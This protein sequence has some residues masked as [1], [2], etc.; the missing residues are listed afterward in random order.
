MTIWRLSDLADAPAFGV[1]G[2]GVE[3]RAVLDWAA[4]NAPRATVHVLDENPDVPAAVAEAAEYRCHLGTERIRELVVDPPFQVLVRS[5]GVPVR[6]E[7]LE[8]A[9]DNGVHVTTLTD[10]WLADDPDVIT[11]GVTGTKGK[12]TTV[13]LLAHVLNQAGWSAALVGNIGRPVLAVDDNHE[14]AVIELS[15]YMLADLH[16]ELDIGVVLNLYREHTDWHGGHEV[17]RADKLRL[18]DLAERVVANRDDPAVRAATTT[19]DP[20]W[21][22][23]DGDDLVCG[24]QRLPAVEVKQA[25]RAAGL[26]GEHNL[27]NAAAALTAAGLVGLDPAGSIGFLSSTP[28]LAHRMEMVASTG[29]GRRWIDDSIATVPE[30]TIAAL[31]TLEGAPLVLIAGGTDRGQ[32]FA[33]LVEVIAT[34]SVIGLAT[35]GPTGPRLAAAVRKRAPDLVVREAEDFDGAVAWADELA[36]ADGVVL[37]SPAAPSYYGFTDFAERGR[38]FAELVVEMSGS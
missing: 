26:A 36:P 34:A 20:V 35:V 22:A 33:E 11:V 29:D 17:Y 3:G 5:P 32:D 16:A 10:L 1:F 15:S 12:S 21:F 2:T 30:A 27:A 4:R 28:T 25:L 18:I 6:H 9:R 7:L 31:K 24:D 13:Q 8:L 37:L 38:R 14:I 19:A 23:L